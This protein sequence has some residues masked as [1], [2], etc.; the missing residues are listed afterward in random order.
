LRMVAPSD[1]VSRFRSTD[2][3]RYNSS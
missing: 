3:F 1:A 2:Y